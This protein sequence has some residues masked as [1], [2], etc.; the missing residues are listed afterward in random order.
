MTARTRL[1]LAIAWRYLRSRRGSRLLS[2]ISVI[3]VAG[4]VVGVSALVV[5]MGVMNGLQTDLREKI[6]VGSPDIRVLTYGAD[7]RMERWDEVL[8]KVRAVEGVVQAAPFVVHQGLATSGTTYTEAI[9]VAGIIPGDSGSAQVTTI[10]DHATAGD[11][12][13]DTPDGERRGAV[14]GALLAQRLNAVPGTALRLITANGEINP[15]LGVVIPRSVEFEVTG[16]FETG[17]YEYDNAYVYVDLDRAREFAGIG[18]AVTGIEIRTTDRWAAPVVAARL[19]SVLGPSYFT[20]DWQQQ[21]SSLFRALKLEK[22]GMAVIL[23]LIIMVAAFNIVSTLTMVVRDKTREIGILKA[24][25]LRA[26]SVRTIF[27]LQGLF[28]GLVGTSVGLAQGVLVGI[29]LERGKLIALDPSVYFID[30]LPVLLDPTDIALIALLS[31]G[32]AVLA[33]LHP[34]GVASRLFPIE[35]I[36]S[37]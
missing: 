26:D 15:L 27:L 32:V 37:E 10:R 17:M 7:L 30:H 20:R 36:R 14:L 34:A 4:V 12:T 13:F 33:T 1:E 35:A 21:N 9:S 3:A 24:M 25:G 16:I 28:I 11:F 2:F 6:L 22:L 23:G 8:A 31:V 19:D 5:I 29:V 18:E